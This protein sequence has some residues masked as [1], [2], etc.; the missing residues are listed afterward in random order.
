[1]FLK[2]WHKQMCYQQKEN[3]KI[4]VEL[5]EEYFDTQAIWDM[6]KPGFRRMSFEGYV[7]KEK[8]KWV[9]WFEKNLRDD[10]TTC[11]TKKILEK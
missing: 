2:R 7:Q 11:Y 9:K 3:C 6:M 1:M 5:I 8:D 10:Y 4:E